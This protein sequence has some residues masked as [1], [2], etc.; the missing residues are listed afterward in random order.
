MYTK[1]IIKCLGAILAFFNISNAALPHSTEEKTITFIRVI[2]TNSNAPIFPI[3]LNTPESEPL[4]INSERLAKLTKKSKVNVI[5]F[6]EDWE[7]DWIMYL[8][9]SY[10]VNQNC[11]VPLFVEKRTY[12][13]YLNQKAK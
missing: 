12:L 10:Q 5:W 1:S 9:E 2:D 6:D 11:N 7:M 3:P 8:R 13:S 4:E